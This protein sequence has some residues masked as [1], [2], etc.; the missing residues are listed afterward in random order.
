VLFVCL[1]PSTAD[2]AK[3]DATVRR[4]V[5]FARKLGFGRL[6]LANLFGLRATCPSELAKATDPVGPENDA[7]ITEASAAADLTVVA[8]G[9]HGR[10][11]RRDRAVLEMLH[12]P[13]CLGTTK[14]GEPRHPLYLSADTHLQKYAC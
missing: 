10:L 2:E 5:G 14:A 12:A 4:C 8:W 7:W 13:Y 6:L 3:D 9:I 1:N 11:Q